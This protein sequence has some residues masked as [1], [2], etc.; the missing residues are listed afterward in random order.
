MVVIIIMIVV[1][2]VVTTTIMMTNGDIFCI[3]W[4]PAGN[5]SE[6]WWAESK[7]I[8]MGELCMEQSSGK[9]MASFQGGLCRMLRTKRIEKQSVLHSKFP[10]LPIFGRNWIKGGGG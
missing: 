1:V 9:S 3:K 10:Q 6:N 2:V 4:F 8:E 5:F 7:G